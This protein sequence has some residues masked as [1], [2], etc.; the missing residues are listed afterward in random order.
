[1][2]QFKPLVDRTI[3]LVR[4]KGLVSIASLAYTLEVS[5]DYARK[6]AKSAAAVSPEPLEI[7]QVWNMET[8]SR[9]PPAICTTNY[10]Q[11]RA[12][13]LKVDLDETKPS[14][15]TRST[16]SHAEPIQ[17]GSIEELESASPSSTSL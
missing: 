8:H 2:E 9:E 4:E 3:A 7:V 6:V 1:M 15:P 17:T 10:L 13:K 16:A 14:T 5:P 11:A 12:A